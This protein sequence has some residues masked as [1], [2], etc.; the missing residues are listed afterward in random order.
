MKNEKSH[1]YDLLWDFWCVISVLGIWPRFIE[2]NLIIPNQLHL[3]LQGLPPYLEGLKIL[4]LSDLHFH[5]Q[6]PQFFLNR[7]VQ[8][9][10]KQ[11]PDL[12][13]LTG[14][15]LCNAQMPDP[16]RLKEFLKRFQAPLGCYAI[17]GNHDYQEK[18]T[19]NQKGDYDV[20]NDASSLIGQGFQRLFSSTQL[21]GKVTEEAARVPPHTALVE[22]LKETP[23]R[24]LDNCTTQITLP[25]GSLNIT[26]VG[27]HMLGRCKPLTAFAAYDPS[28]PGI[29]LAHNPDALPSLANYPGEVVLCGHTHGAQINLP[30]MWRYLTLMENTQFKRGLL[31]YQNKWVVVN[32]GIG[33]V[34]PFR[35][36]S[37]PETILITL[38][39]KN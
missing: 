6:I 38:H 14:D 15:F 28:F 16:Q 11:R 33:S 22:L 9:S 3:P 21:T 23:F 26:G 30:I 35:W 20:S 32:R 24:L 34:M 31:S 18:I 5:P 10:A 2:P 27:E 7:L 13:V 12:I 19:V 39:A 25:G 8:D 1:F 37:P 36:F 29:V 4:H 17:L